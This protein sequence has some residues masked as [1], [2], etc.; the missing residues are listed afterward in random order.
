MFHK[1][2]LSVSVVLLF[3]AS[4]FV[5]AEDKKA[6]EPKAKEEKKEGEKT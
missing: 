6:A 5:I 2:L 1:K 4:V 3:I